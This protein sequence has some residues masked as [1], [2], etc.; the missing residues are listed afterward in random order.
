[1]DGSVKASRILKALCVFGD[2]SIVIG[3]DNEQYQKDVGSHRFDEWNMRLLCRLLG[4]PSVLM[5]KRFS[6]ASRI[7]RTAACWSTA[8]YEEKLTQSTNLKHRMGFSVG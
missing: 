5:G 2:Q 3:F 7:A 1:M 8:G 6:W 4:S